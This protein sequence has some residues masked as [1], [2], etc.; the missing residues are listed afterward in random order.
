[1][2]KKVEQQVEQQVEQVT[3]KSI[4]ERFINAGK[5]D[6]A[7]P[8]VQRWLTFSTRIATADLPEGVTFEQMARKFEL[9]FAP[10]TKVKKNEKKLNGTK[11]LTSITATMSD[12][13]GK[14]WIRLYYYR[15]KRELRLIVGVGEPDT[16]DERNWVSLM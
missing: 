12:T 13:Q 15:K 1:M 10:G 3:I 5:L 4:V 7:K 11:V 16:S 14:C 8:V 9:T 2:Q 6:R